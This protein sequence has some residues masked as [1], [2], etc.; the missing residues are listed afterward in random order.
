MVFRAAPML[1][2]RNGPFLFTL[3]ATPLAIGLRFVSLHAAHVIVS[4]KTNGKT[5]DFA[6]LR[7]RQCATVKPAVQSAEM[8]ASELRNF[9]RGVCFHIAYVDWHI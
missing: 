3:S 6:A 5:A 8:D 1:T 2:H 7:L 4:P 9:G